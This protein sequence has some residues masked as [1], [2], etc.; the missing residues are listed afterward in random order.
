MEQ[1]Q[2]EDTGADGTSLERG[3]RGRRSTFR[4]RIQG[5][6]EQEQSTA[7]G[8]GRGVVGRAGVRGMV[9]RLGL[10]G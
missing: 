9:G 8:Q 7:Q 3:Y 2:R 6:M 5:Q 4:E 1:A 10:E